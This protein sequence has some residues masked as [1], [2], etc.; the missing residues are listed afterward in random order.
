MCR[1]RLQTLTAVGSSLVVQTSF[2]HRCGL[3]KNDHEFKVCEL[4]KGKLHE[5]PMSFRV[6]YLCQWKKT[7]V[8]CSEVHVLC[9]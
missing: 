8:S 5:K 3:F 2:G 4:R 9:D 6:E 1:P 7:S